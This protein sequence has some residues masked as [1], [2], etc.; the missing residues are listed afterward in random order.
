MC[1]ICKNTIINKKEILD[2]SGCNTLTKIP[3]IPGLKELY[4]CNCP[5]LIEIFPIK[6]LEVLNCS[7]CTSLTT[8]PYIDRLRV[9]LCLNCP[10]I[11]KIVCGHGLEQ[12]NCFNCTTLTHILD[13][14]KS[15]LKQLVCTLCRNLLQIPPKKYRYLSATK[16]AWLSHPSNLEYDENI[17]KLKILQRWIKKVVIGKRIKRLIPSLMPLYYHPEAK[18]GYFHKKRILEFIDSLSH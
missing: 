15:Q 9:L 4:C 14:N 11:T 18:G 7:R 8:I 17:G 10:V 16:C 2:C 1:R 3:N 13:D 6:S 5:M 12:I